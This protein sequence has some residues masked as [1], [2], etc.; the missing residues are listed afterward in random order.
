MTNI[1]GWEDIIYKSTASLTTYNN[2][3]FLISTYIPIVCQTGSL[4][5]GIMR[6]KQT[7]V[8]KKG[9][10]ERKRRFRESLVLTE[11]SRQGE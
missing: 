8:I 11:N 6:Y 9:K 10:K 3:F 4:V 7:K 1:P 2:F 5:F